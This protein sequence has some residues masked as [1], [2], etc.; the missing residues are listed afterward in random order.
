MISFGDEETCTHESTQPI[1]DEY[2]DC[3]CGE[4]ICDDCGAGFV[5]IKVGN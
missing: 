1:D 5:P 2:S 3:K 4:I